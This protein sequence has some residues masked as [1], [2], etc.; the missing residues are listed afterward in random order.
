ML[1][2]QEKLGT[3]AAQLDAI[4]RRIRTLGLARAADDLVKVSAELRALRSVLPS[5]TSAQSADRPGPGTGSG[6]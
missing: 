5:R 6:S 4:I 3:L 2:V 1:I